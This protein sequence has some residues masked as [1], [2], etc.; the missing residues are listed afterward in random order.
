M[1]R[2]TTR[3]PER[4]ADHAGGG[5]A[6]GEAEGGDGAGALGPARVGAGEGGEVV[7]VGEAGDG[8]VGLRL[9]VGGEDAVL[10]LGLELGHAAAVEEVGDERGDEDGLAGAAEAGDAEADHRV[11]EDGAEVAHRVLDGVDQAPGQAIEVQRSRPLPRSPGA[12]YSL[13]LIAP[14]NSGA[15]ST[16]PARFVRRQIVPRLP[17]R[18]RRASR[19]SRA[20]AARL[21]ASGK[22][23]PHSPYASLLRA[24]DRARL[25]CSLAF[26]VR[27]KRS[28]PA[29]EFEPK[30]SAGNRT[31]DLIAP[32]PARNDAALRVAPRPR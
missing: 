20:G 17:A 14:P 23:A 10:G 13:R 1:S 28:H 2:W 8:V 32:P 19:A 30:Q 16:V 26:S 22:R 12:P 11:G 7:L 31:S 9:Q 29:R 21:P 18:G 5:D 6:E 4:P 27:G 3:G 25:H 24:T 15:L